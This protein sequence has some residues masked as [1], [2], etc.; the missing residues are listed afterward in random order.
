MLQD[1]AMYI[2]DIANNSIRA[3]A[4][5]IQIN[6]KDS[7]KENMVLISIQDDGCGMDQEQLHQVT[8]PFYTSRTTRKIGLGVSLFKELAERCNGSFLI[9]SEKGN[10][11]FIQAELE[12]T[13]WDVPPMGNLSE[14]LVTLIQADQTIEYQ[15]HYLTDQKEFLLDTVEIK[16]VLEG[17]SLIEPSILLWLKDYIG[18]GLTL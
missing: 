18:E 10:G 11:T 17:V 4:Q 8:N 2:L 5:N 1:I 7:K 14:M 3:K 6:V 16:K 12:R 15:F 9:Q 13:H